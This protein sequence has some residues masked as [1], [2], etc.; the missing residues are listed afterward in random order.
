MRACQDGQDWQA[1]QGGKGGLREESEPGR[2]GAAL[3]EESPSLGLLV[4]QVPLWVSCSAP[5][6]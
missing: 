2:L 1:G 3:Q 6:L 4:P 5:T